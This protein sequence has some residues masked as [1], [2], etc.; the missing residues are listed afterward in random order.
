VVIGNPPYIQLSEITGYNFR[1]YSCAACGNIYPIILERCLAI[2]AKNGYQG[3]I[4]PVSSVS[5]DGYSSLVF[6]HTYVRG[7]PWSAKRSRVA[8]PGRVLDVRPALAGVVEGA[9]PAAEAR[10]PR[11]RHLVKPASSGDGAVRPPP[12][13]GL[14]RRRAGA[15]GGT[16][17]P[18]SV[19]R[20]GAGDVPLR[21]L[22]MPSSP[23]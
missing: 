14:W 9:V 12:R 20:K 22:N 16:Q 10:G 15:N 6:T 18:P 21:L 23:S 17:G 7:R 8:P 2:S 19:R 3:Y 13:G 4:V 1:S 11:P 5:T